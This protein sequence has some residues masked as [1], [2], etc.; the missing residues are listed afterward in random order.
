M[1]ITIGGLPGSG[2]STLAGK[3][4]GKFNLIVISAGDTF[5][6]LAAEHNMSLKEFGH[7][8]EK[9]QDIDKQLD[10]QQQKIAQHRNNVIL[11]GRLAGHFIE[12]ATTRIWL[13]APIEVRA[14]RI[15]HREAETVT[16]TIAE[17]RTREECEASRY[18]NYYQLNINDLA[19]YDIILDTA[20]YTKEQTTRIISEAVQNHKQ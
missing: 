14:A 16:Q 19:I 11:E 1:K 3:L 12:D 15:A 18:K 20:R 8:A 7:L 4:A 2:T 10:K 6:K 9:D 17:I 5:R 13:K